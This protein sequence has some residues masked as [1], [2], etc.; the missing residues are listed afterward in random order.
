MSRSRIDIRNR[1]QTGT[2]AVEVLMA[3]TTFAIAF[4]TLAAMTTTAKSQTKMNAERRVALE[5]AQEQI[6][7]LKNTPF[8]AVYRLFDG[9]A[10]NDGALQS[11]GDQFDV[12]G[13]EPSP[14]DTDGRCG[15][16]ILPTRV[17]PPDGE[18]NQPPP[19]LWE[20]FSDVKLG[21]PADLDGDG[22]IDDSPKDG[23]YMHLPVRVEVRW[24]G[25][26]GEQSL[27]VSTWLTPRR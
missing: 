27:S 5:A 7:Q 23:S 20:R 22:L 16:I 4:L 19:Y 10:H 21:L 8:E 26:V 1:D 18:G 12:E 14:D 24:T 25:A 13:L 2:S 17:P 11:P 6:E 9:S 15:R 3:I